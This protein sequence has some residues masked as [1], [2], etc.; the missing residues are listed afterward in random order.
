MG[1]G[2]A[3]RA[4]SSNWSSRV[5]VRRPE[6]VPGAHDIELQVAH[7]EAGATRT[8]GIAERAPIRSRID[9]RDKVA[10]LRRLEHQRR[11]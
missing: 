8:G 5:T 2:A 10:A 4:S 9:A 6:E 7:L 11:Q 1:A 3:R